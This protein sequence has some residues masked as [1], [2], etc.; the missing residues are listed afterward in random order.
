[1]NSFRVFSY[2]IVHN[3][4]KI[5]N[6]KQFLGCPLPLV[7]NFHQSPNFHCVT[8]ACR[9]QQPEVLGQPAPTFPPLQPLPERPFC[10]PAR[11]LLP[12]TYPSRRAAPLFLRS[13]FR[14]LYQ[15][16]PSSGLLGIYQCIIHKELII[17][18]FSL[19]VFFNM[20]VK[21]LW[22]QVDKGNTQ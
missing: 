3:I 21:Y 2:F 1:M 9:L 19:L 14:P 18:S 10:L 6:P 11:F 20:Y 8:Q 16:L 15:A 7:K 12:G 4:N 17:C 5:S 22:E 13:P